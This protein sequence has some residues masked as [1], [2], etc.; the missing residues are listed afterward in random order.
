MILRNWKTVLI[1]IALLW[2]CSNVSPSTDP[3]SNIS[4]PVSN[5]QG[6]IA[7]PTFQAELPPQIIRAAVQ[8]TLSAGSYKF[9]H[10][11]TIAGPHNEEGTLFNG[12]VTKTGVHLYLQEFQADRETPIDII[13]QIIIDGWAY[14]R[15]SPEGNESVQWIRYPYDGGVEVAFTYLT[16]PLNPLVG[17]QISLDDFEAVGVEVLDGQECT[18]FQSENI[19]KAWA[20]DEELLEKDSPMLDLL[21][22]AAYRVWIC[23]DGYVH[24]LQASAKFLVS[25]EGNFISR[26]VL[27]RLWGYDEVITISPP[28]NFTTAEEQ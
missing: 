12:E 18:I 24:Q 13:E 2:G 14:T 8:R 23:A 28:S 10:E 26:S 22:H 27:L 4:S 20:A 15:L 9:R 21:N 16:K 3:A 6:V 25:D 11:W 1:C 17:D 7:S 5:G 19:A